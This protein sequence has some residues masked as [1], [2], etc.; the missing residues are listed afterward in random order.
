MSDNIVRACGFFNPQ[1]FELSQLFH[2]VNGLNKIKIINI[3]DYLSSAFLNEMIDYNL[4]RIFTYY[5][6]YLKAVTCMYAMSTPFIK[7]K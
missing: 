5:N 6:I 2:P 4:S 7:L 1:R 3:R